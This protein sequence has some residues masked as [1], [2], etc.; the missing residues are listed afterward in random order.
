MSTHKGDEHIS[1]TGAVHVLRERRHAGHE[2]WTW[3]YVAVGGGRLIRMA[4][5]R[6]GEQLSDDEA[7]ERLTERQTIETAEA[8]LE[9]SAT[10]YRPTIPYVDGIANRKPPAAGQTAGGFQSLPA[11]SVVRRS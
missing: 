11:A 1:F 2:Y 8:Y 7:E 6:S 4:Y 10:T 9:A 3:G 5:P